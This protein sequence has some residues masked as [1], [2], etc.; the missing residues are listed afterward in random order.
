M[1]N[2]CK[3]HEYINTVYIHICANTHVHEYTHTHKNT[4][5]NV[6]FVN[7]ELI[8][9]DQSYGFISSILQQVNVVQLEISALGL[10]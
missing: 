4:G 5:L 8:Y 6:S 9:H 3:L 2:I 1:H 7:R 10:S